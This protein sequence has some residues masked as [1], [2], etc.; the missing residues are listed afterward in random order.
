MVRFLHLTIYLL[1]LSHAWMH[2]LCSVQRQKRDSQ[3]RRRKVKKQR[4]ELRWQ[5]G[6]NT[7]TRLSCSTHLQT[8]API[9]HVFIE[10]III[11]PTHPE[12]PLIQSYIRHVAT[13]STRWQ[14][15]ASKKQFQRFF[16][17]LPSQKGSLLARTVVWTQNQRVTA[18]F[19]VWTADFYGQ[20]TINKRNPASNA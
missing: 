14:W 18:W 2:Q 1:L 20:N 4:Y 11:C 19:R 16:F 6:I 13:M 10:Q 9:S 8:Y 17:W 7:W 3:C 15:F 5:L 12:I